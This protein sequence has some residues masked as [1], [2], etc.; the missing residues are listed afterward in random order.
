MDDDTLPTVLAD[1]PAIELAAPDGARARVLLHGAQ[2][3]SWRPAGGTERLYLSPRAEAGAGRAVRGGVPVI[4][5]QFGASGPLP[6]HGF[7]RDRAWVRVA[8]EVGRDDALAVLRLADDERTRVLWPHRFAAELT[9]RV[10]GARLD[11]ELAVE[12]TGDDAVAFT[13]ALHSYLRVADLD[14]ARLQ[15]LQRLRRRDQVRGTEQIEGNDALRIDGEVDRVYF[16]AAR[17]LQLQDALGSLR[18]GAEGFRD[19][20][21]WNPGPIQSASLADL[22]PDGFRHFICV[23]A[24]AVGTPVRLEPGAEWVGRQSLVDEG[25]EARRD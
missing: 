18:I 5:P 20:V 8:T 21:V 4:F 16:D 19:V 14:A 13:A 11:V 9:V 7:A 23:E 24:A 3:V 6:R 10:G 22:P 1:Q 2:V 15:G 25:L 17:A 12:N